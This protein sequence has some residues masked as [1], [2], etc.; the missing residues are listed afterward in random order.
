MVYLYL[1]NIFKLKRVEMNLSI[2]DVVYDIKYPISVI[3]AIEKNDQDFLPKPYSYYC[4]KTYGQYLK[5]SNLNN[6]LK[7]YK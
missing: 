2:A 7:G 4:V 3:E 1:M 5:I 6:I